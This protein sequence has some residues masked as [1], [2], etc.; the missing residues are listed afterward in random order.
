MNRPPLP[1]ALNPHLNVI[2]N[3]EVPQVKYQ[4]LTCQGQDILVGRMKISTPTQTSG[5]AF[6]LRRYDTGAVSATT[7]FRAAEGELQWIKDTYDLT[8]NNGSSRDTDTNLALELAGHYAL[9][10]LMDEVVAATPNPNGNYRRSGKSGGATATPKGSEANLTAT[11]PL[12]PVSP[13]KS[14]TSPVD[15]PPTKR[16]KPVASPATRSPSPAYRSSPPA[17]RRSTRAK[18]PSFRAAAAEL[19]KS[20]RTPRKSTQKVVHSEL[21]SQ[22]IAE[23][24]D[25]INGLKAQREV[26]SAEEENI[27]MEYPSKNKRSREDE[28]PLKFEPKPQAPESRVIATNRRVS[29]FHLE[30]KTKS[31]AWGVA[32]FV[33]G[34]GAVTLLPNLF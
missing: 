6:I 23:Q 21:Y 27:D 28:K 30:P 20:S 25:L 17:P 10:R 18:S 9:G 5:H 1:T 2:L 24:K 4:I 31:V 26:A 13:N 3:T 8:G 19:P 7:M 16:R 12:K 14:R 15:E 33:F 32:A 34:A 22:D 29:R 11:T